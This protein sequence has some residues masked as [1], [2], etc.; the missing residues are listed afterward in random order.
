[1]SKERARRRAERERVAALKAAARAAEQE[2][3]ERRAA[4]RRAV[5]SRLPAFGRGRQTGILARRRR[6]QTTFLVC[7]LL[8]LNVLVWVVWDDWAMR[9][10]GFVVSVLAAPVIHTLAFRR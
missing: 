1:M 5:T 7:L 8:A 6:T 10:A 9:L 2:R 4:R 3:A